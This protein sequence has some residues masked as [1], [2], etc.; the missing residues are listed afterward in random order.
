[1]IP[2]AIRAI[3]YRA[4]HG[5]SGLTTAIVNN[6]LEEI[7]LGAF[8]RC[9][10]L[11]H[12]TIPPAVRVIKC[13]AFDCCSGLR[14]VTLGNGLEEI[15]EGAFARCTSLICVA[16][17]PTIAAIHEEASDECSNLTNVRFCDEIEEFVSRESV[18]YW[19]DHGVHKKCLSTYCIF[20]QCNIPERVSLALPRMWLSYIYDMQGGIP[21][22][23]SKGLNSNFHS[24]DS[25]LCVYKKLKDAL[26][27]LE[28]AIWKLEIIEQTDRNIDHLTTDIKM[29]CCIDS[30]WMVELSSQ[31]CC[32]S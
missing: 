24:I 14:T 13:N 26:A 16:I 23:S 15:R 8:A 1:V 28:L 25:K 31:M 27:M 2:P 11:V 6:G 5:C 12:I 7:R 9:T 3:K 17:P 20:V 30:L 10:S 32:P 19:W 22:I 29:E 4:F 18:R 21:S